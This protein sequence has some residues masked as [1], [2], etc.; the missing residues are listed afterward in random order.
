MSPT[1]KIN[2]KEKQIIHGLEYQAKGFGLLCLAVESHGR[3]EN[4]EACSSKESVDLICTLDKSFPVL[5]GEW[6]AGFRLEIG[7][8]IGKC[9]GILSTENRVGSN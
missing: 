7:R 1:K 8:T 6:L 3:F 9:G 5:A 2:F 4:S